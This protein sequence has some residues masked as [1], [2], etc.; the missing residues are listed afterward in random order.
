MYGVFHALVR[1]EFSSIHASVIQFI[2]L[3][4]VCKTNHSVVQIQVIVDHCHATI[5]PYQKYLEKYTR[6][7]NNLVT[8]N[9]TPIEFITCIKYCDVEYLGIVSNRD[10]HFICFYDFGS[11]PTPE[12][13]EELMNL[14]ETW[15]WQSNR[16]I[17]IDIFLFAEMQRFRP[18]LKT[19]SLKETEIM[20]G[21]VTSLQNLSRKRVKRR[22]LQLIRK[23][24]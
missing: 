17:P 20:Y 24:D 9:N 23:M 18:Y 14:G 2:A 4:S 21:P 6:P 15:W 11:V 1:F 19:F 10:N 3:A 8:T 16:Q 12:M 22:T 13:R 7:I 5:Y